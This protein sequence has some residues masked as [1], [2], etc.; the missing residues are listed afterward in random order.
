MDSPRP[1]NVAEP[2]NLE[3]ALAMYIAARRA[4]GFKL[5]DY[6]RPLRRFIEFLGKQNSPTIT[7]ALVR[8]FLTECP[9]CAATKNLTLSKIRGFATYRCLDDIK[10]EVPPCC[11]VDRVERRGVF[12]SLDQNDR[13]FFGQA[14]AAASRASDMGD[15]F[16]V[17]TTRFSCACYLVFW[18][19]NPIDKI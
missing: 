19:F 11:L 12:R 3:T 7:T 5:R 9:G 16:M 1:A 2:V 6:A 8:E 4:L 14:P 17:L 13:C 18:H 10:A 15:M